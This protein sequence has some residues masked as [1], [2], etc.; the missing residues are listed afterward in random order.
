MIYY[1]VLGLPY[2]VWRPTTLPLPVRRGEGRGEGSSVCSASHGPVSMSLQSTVR[3]RLSLA[4]IQGPTCRRAFSAPWSSDILLTFAGR[5]RGDLK[6]QRS[7][8]PRSGASGHPESGLLGQAPANAPLPSSVA[9]QPPGARG[10]PHAHAQPSRAETTGG[11]ATRSQWGEARAGVA[12]ETTD[13]ADDSPVSRSAEHGQSEESDQQA[14][15]ARKGAK[16]QTEVKN[17]G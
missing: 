17:Y 6:G 7:S 9:G 2:G 3:G 11:H 12:T 13:D 16:C 4:V 10:T 5:Q 15:S 8:A 14:L 1:S